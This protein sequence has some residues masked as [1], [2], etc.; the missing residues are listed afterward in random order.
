MIYKP[1]RVRDREL[2]DGGHRPPPRTSTSRSRRGAKLIVVVNTRSSR[3]VNDFSKTIPTLFGTRVRAR[4]GHGLPEDRLPDLQAARLPATARDGEATGKSATPGV[5][6]IL[7]EP[8]PRRRADVSDE[9]SSISPHGWRVARH[10]FES[11]T[12]KLAKDYEEMSEVCRRHGIR[13]LRHNG[14]ARW[15]ATFSAEREKTRAWRRILE[16]TTG[17]LPASERRVGGRTLPAWTSTVH[18]QIPPSRSFQSRPAS[19]ASS[20]SSRWTFP[21]HRDRREPRRRTRFRSR[22]R[23]RSVRSRRPPDRGALCVR[24]LRRPQ[25]HAG[26]TFSPDG[27]GHVDRGH[28]RRRSARPTDLLARD[29]SVKLV[30][31][32]LNTF[33]VSVRVGPERARA[34]RAWGPARRR[35]PT[36]EE[37]IP[38]AVSGVQGLEALGVELVDKRCA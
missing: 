28:L 37:S 18:A 11:V 34:R 33:D 23:S 36:L 29:A 17:A 12:L 8:E 6:I 5:D 13:D 30:V 9:T 21:D 26:A 4:L 15:S 3:T 22:S 10:G 24:R 14:S 35:A 1:H 2:V 38:D 19:Q 20:L 27:Q 32:Y 7:I 25:S 16:Q 31:L